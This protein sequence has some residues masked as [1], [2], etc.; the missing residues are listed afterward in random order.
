MG[1]V[2]IYAQKFFQ[3]FLSSREGGGTNERKLEIGT[4]PNFGGPGDKNFF[5]KVY[6]LVNTVF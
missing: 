3:N 5:A 1:R 6:I 4:A 2:W